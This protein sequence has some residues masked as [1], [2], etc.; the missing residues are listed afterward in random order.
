MSERFMIF[1]ESSGDVPRDH[2]LFNV[3][4]PSVVR[5]PQWLPDRPGEYLL[6]FAHHLGTHVRMAWADEII[7][8]WTVHDGGVLHVDE[9]PSQ[10]TFPHLAS[11]DVHVLDDERRL[12]M[13]FH[14]PV[15]ETIGAHLPCWD[16]YPT[17]RQ[18][19]LVAESADGR[20]FTVI[21]QP[22]IAPS[23]L[24]MVRWRDAWIG[25]AMPTQLVRSRDGVHDVEYGPSLLA[26]DEIRHC[27]LLV[28]GDALRL[29][30]TRA[31]DAPELILS[32]T[33]D[34]TGDWSDW[35]AGDPVE[36]LRPQE[37]WEGA[38]VAI[39]PSLR[40]PGGAREHALRDPYVFTDTD[41]S[42][43]LFYSGAGEFALGVTRLP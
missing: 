6:Y 36:V 43:W 17:G 35:R 10:D 37:T 26:D 19:T 8:P 15:G 16:T 12:R 11:P 13:Y 1:D 29:W 3:N 25:M 23:Y 5:A 38:D 31:G 32:A 40:G 39:A 9:T 21:D 20:S 18:K 22:A 14:A 24:R 41:G 27:A 34:L 7:G 42:R 30:W 4:G 2:G 28:D 33:V